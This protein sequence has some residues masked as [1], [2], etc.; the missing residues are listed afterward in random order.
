[1]DHVA[2]AQVLC[3][4]GQARAG[5][6]LLVSIAGAGCPLSTPCHRQQCVC[7]HHDDMHAITG[8]GQAAPA[9]QSC[10]NMM[11]LHTRSTA[12]VCVAVSGN[13][14]SH[15]PGVLPAPC[16]LLWKMNR[17]DTH[18][19][20]L[21]KMAGTPAAAKC[22]VVQPGGAMLLGVMYGRPPTH[23][24][25]HAPARAPPHLLQGGQVGVGGQG[26]PHCHLALHHAA[27]LSQVL[28]LDHLRDGEEGGGRGVCVCVHI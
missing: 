20:T 6:R 25:H 11:L 17:R 28:L 8:T 14:C 16:F 22:K 12:V 1:M 27:Q 18:T 13:Q 3:R 19:T 5:H 2:T 9:S 4:P 15:L 10:S 26:A 21:G 7:G 24:V 23:D